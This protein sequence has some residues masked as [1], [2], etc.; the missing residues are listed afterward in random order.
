MRCEHD[1]KESSKGPFDRE[2]KNNLMI[3]FGLPRTRRHEIEPGI[4]RVR[5]VS[6][7]KSNSP[8]CNNNPI[9]GN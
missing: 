2:Y 5:S 8:L 3:V 6:L 4:L 7:L 1:K 9:E